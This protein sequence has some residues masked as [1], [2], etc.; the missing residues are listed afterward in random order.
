[1]AYY[2]IVLMVKNLSSHIAM[3][4]PTLSH[5]FSVCWQLQVALVA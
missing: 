5:C 1:M 3:S 4:S 2:L